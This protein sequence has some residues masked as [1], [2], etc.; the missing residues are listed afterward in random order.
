MILHLSAVNVY[1]VKSINHSKIK[2]SFIDI[3]FLTYP[4]RQRKMT[5]LSPTT[6]L[7]RRKEKLQMSIK[8]K[9]YAKLAKFSTKN[10]AAENF[11]GVLLGNTNEYRR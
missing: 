11:A 4:F 9:V 8:E 10:F 2:H 5:W 7:M 6:K 1:A 3:T